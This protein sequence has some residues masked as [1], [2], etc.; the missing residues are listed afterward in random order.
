MNIAQNMWASLVRT[1]TPIVVGFVVNLLVGFGWD[2]DQSEVEALVSGAI[3]AVAAVL[4]YVVA[5]VLELYVNPRFGW[6]LGSSKSPDSYSEEPVARGGVEGGLL[7]DDVHAVDSVAIDP[8]E[9]DEET[10]V[11][12]TGYEQVEGDSTPPP[13]SYVPRHRA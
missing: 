4:W 9:Y 3:T 1:V 10:G 11:M 8:V 6:L 7:S 5:R 13:E 12:I 2:I